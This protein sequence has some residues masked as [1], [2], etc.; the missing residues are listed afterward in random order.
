MPPIAHPDPSRGETAPAAVGLGRIFIAFLR[1]GSTAFGGGTA[2]WLYREIVLRRR[3]IEDSRFLAL[4]AMVQVMPGS[5]GVNLTVLIGRELH[6]ALGAAAA[7]TGLL[8]V[9]FA[10]VLL[11][12]TVYAGAGEHPVVTAMLDGVAAMVIGLTFATG[13]GS[14]ARGTTDPAAWAIAAATVFGIGVMR[15]PLLPVIAALTP[16]S[17]GLA[18][19]RRRR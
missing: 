16:V 3:W 19:A 14:L 9:P 11:I 6:G 13:L 18:L 1:L 10:V 2:G 4:L 15:W 17:V 8:T 7:V 5:N 12:G